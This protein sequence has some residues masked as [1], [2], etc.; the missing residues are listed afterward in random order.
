MPQQTFTLLCHRDMPMAMIT[1]P[2]IIHFLEPSQNL[3]IVDDGS[4]TVEDIFTLKKLSPI[5]RIITRHE[6]EDYILDAIGNR[7][8]CKQY[9]EE[10]P[11]AFKLIDIPLLAGKDS[12][13]YTFTDTDIIYLKNC[14]N[15]FNQCVNTYLRTD[16][17]KLSVKL[18]NAFLKYK[19]EIP[20]R[21]NS[22]YF[23]YD[24][25][26]F[27]LDFIEYFLGLPDVRNSP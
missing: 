15:Y 2:K 12:H 11:L 7:P 10:F 13:R 18:Q 27:D 9:R 3:V 21:F 4:L 22:G 6:R 24:T 25:R 26:S 8:N 1:L 16:A 19:W 23:S 14:K 20:L 17:I 5:V